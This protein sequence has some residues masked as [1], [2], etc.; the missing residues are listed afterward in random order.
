MSAAGQILVIS[1]ILRLPLTLSVWVGRLKVIADYCLPLTVPNE[2]D[3]APYSRASRQAST[4]S[5]RSNRSAEL[6]MK[7]L[8]FLYMVAGLMTASDTLA[9]IEMPS[10]GGVGLGVTPAADNRLQVRAWD[11]KTGLYLSQST[12]AGTAATGIYSFSQGGTYSRGIFTRGAS[13]SSNNYGI[14][15][16]AQGGSTAYG[17]FAS[18]SGASNNNYAGYFTGDL[19]YTGNLIAVSDARFKEMCVHLTT[20]EYSRAYYS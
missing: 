13:A 11:R 1:R 19:G 10:H 5:T 14:H 20:P 16:N 15:A 6:N 2:R 17:V 18:A 7:P 3:G 4:N 12:S 9:Q 8:L